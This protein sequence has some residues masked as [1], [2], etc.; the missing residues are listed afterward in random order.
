M[1]V[2]HNCHKHSKEE[3]HMAQEVKDSTVATGSDIS[4]LLENVGAA[5][6]EGWIPEGHIVTRGQHVTQAMI[7]LGAISQ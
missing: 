7:K 6:A 3:V 1:Y 4:E 2:H 5:R